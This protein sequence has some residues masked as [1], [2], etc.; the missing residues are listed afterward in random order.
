[1][2]WNN[3][4]VAYCRGVWS[5]ISLFI[6][7]FVATIAGRPAYLNPLS[8]LPNLILLSLLA[9]VFVAPFSG[10]LGVPMLLL[11]LFRPRTPRAILI[12][13]LVVTM[14]ANYAF[15][16]YANHHLGS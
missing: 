13:S 3:A 10:L 7:E 4:V 6:F 15:D 9:P 5:T 2:V 8:N 11:Y 1:V 16:L 12:V 14:T